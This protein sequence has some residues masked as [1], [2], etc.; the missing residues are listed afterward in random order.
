MGVESIVSK[1]LL[2]QEEKLYRSESTSCNIEPDGTVELGA[3]KSMNSFRL[4]L[5]E[6]NVRDEQQAVMADASLTIS[7]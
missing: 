1:A 7:R 6:G 4:K 5:P 2:S 3:K